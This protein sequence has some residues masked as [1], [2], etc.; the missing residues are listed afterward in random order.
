MWR[1]SCLGSWYAGHEIVLRRLAA[2][3]RRR[4][5]NGTRPPVRSSVPAPNQRRIYADMLALLRQDIANVEAGIY[6]LP[7]DHD[8]SL[9]TRFYRSR[10]FFDDLPEIHRRRERSGFQEAL[11]EGPGKTAGLLPAEFPFSIRWLDDR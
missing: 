8:G 4:S 6:P 11:R 9:L 1:D 5:G 2:E 7:H 3:A 10:L